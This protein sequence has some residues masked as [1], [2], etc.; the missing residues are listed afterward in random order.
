MPNMKSRRRVAARCVATRAQRCIALFGSRAG[1]GHLL[2][3]APTGKGANVRV[4]EEVAQ[5][6]YKSG[7][8]MVFSNSDQALLGQAGN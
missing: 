1:A 8:T 2:V 7:G 6:A 4:P 5:A 3:V